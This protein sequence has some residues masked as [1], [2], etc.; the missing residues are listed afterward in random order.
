[1]EGKSFDTESVFGFMESFHLSDDGRSS[2]APCMNFAQALILLCVLSTAGVRAV[3]QSAGL[4]HY[5]GRILAGPTVFDGTGQ[6]K[7][8]LVNGGGSQT[9][10]RNA[11]DANNDS[12]PDQAVSVSVTRGLYSVNLGDTAL[13]N[14]AAIPLPV[15]TDNLG[16][17]QSNPLYLRV[18]FNDG[19]SGF[20]RLSPDQRLGAVAFAMVAA[21]VPDGSIT[22][23]KLAAGA[24]PASS[25]TGILLPT[26]IPGLDAAKLTGGTLDPARLPAAVALNTQITSLQSQINTLSAQVA[27]LAGGAGSGAPGAVLVSSSA[28]DAALQG[29]GYV[30]FTSVAAPSWIT[31]ATLNAPAAR[32]GHA[33]T[34]MGGDGEVFVWGGQVGAGSLSASGGL[35]RPTSDE[36][37]IAQP[38]GAPDARRGHTVI[39][40]GSAA[41]VWGGFA[42]AGY[43][44]TGGRFDPASFSWQPI[45]TVNAPVAR[46]S[47]V[48]A[49]F[50]PYMVVWGG[51]NS[52]GP[53]SDGSLYHTANGVWTPLA[54]A[55][56]P[57]ARSGAAAA[58]GT[59]R[60][61]IWG[62]TGA[63]GALN[64]GAQLVFQTSPT[65]TPLEWRTI[66]IVN[67]PSARSAHTA[68]MAGAK[69][70]VW[71]GRNG[72]TLLG[73]GAIYN[74]ATDT[75]LPMS[76]T[77]APSPRSDHS[78]VWT[79][80]EMVVFGGETASGTTATGAAYN[81]TTDHWR[82]LTPAGD[83]VA[84][85]G[86]GAV[87]TGS[88]FVVFGGQ[89]GPLPVAALQRLS[90]QPT[91]Y[92]YRK[93]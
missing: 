20:Q 57:S 28:A 76:A 61:L 38:V 45:T 64:T 84:R 62:G 43:Q 17:L 29:L 58:T 74:P 27:V 12:E 75:W 85:S 36:W 24:V 41:Y 67:A 44:N 2:C 48:A 68:V 26:Q 33:A 79:G 52:A 71:G 63:A 37:R 14:M 21:T 90:P 22:A 50:A 25:L 31:G 35:Y 42:D 4:I 65:V 89:S 34:W 6:F 56:A 80:T 78:A 88:E 49:W 19:S 92:F 70:I 83:P 93:P 40:D 54:L 66:S 9:L 46:D 72:G 87:W 15:F 39:W 60:I 55:N 5:Q 91:W 47:H 8:S 59:D 81:P 86:A 51:R 16:G 77:D 30:A 1:M 69:L 82:A 13:S 23:A 7:F 10:W 32:Y 53:R 11:P 18:W 73:D 3:A